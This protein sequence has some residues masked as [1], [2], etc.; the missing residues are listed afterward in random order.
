V[1]NRTRIFMRRIPELIGAI[2]L[3]AIASACSGPATPRPQAASIAAPS[4]SPASPERAPARPPPDRDA[5]AD[6]HGI[7]AA[8]RA[9]IQL[10]YNVGKPD[11]ATGPA[12]RTAILAFQKD[13]A[14][15][16]DGRLTFA[17]AGML[18]ALAAQ[19]SRIGSTAVAAGDTVFFSDGSSEVVKSERIV[20]WEQNGARDVVAIRPSTSGWPP[21]ARAGLDWATTHALDLAD[22]PA[23]EWSSTGVDRHFQIYATS[24]LLP[25][26]ATIAGSAASSCRHFELR[27]DGPQKHYPGV[28]CLDAKRQ[29]FVPHSRIRLARPATDLGPQATPDGGGSKMK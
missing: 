14:L 3:A 9:L 13:H 26:E 16:E 12:T 28:A 25:R 4:A 19:L 22:S 23:I 11:G 21:A 8:Q 24:T 7:A 18:N 6:A 1:K 27:G 29:W 10:G 17:L 15:S 2:V 5:V 20:F